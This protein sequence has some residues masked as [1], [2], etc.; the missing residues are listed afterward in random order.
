MILY[1]KK[2]TVVDGEMSTNEFE[3]LSERYKAVVIIQKHIKRRISQ[4]MLTVQRR[5]SVRIQSGNIQLFVKCKACY[6]ERLAQLVTET[7][8][9]AEAPGF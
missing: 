9:V 2:I 8:K 6:R 1:F 4:T 5:A 7:I 3:L